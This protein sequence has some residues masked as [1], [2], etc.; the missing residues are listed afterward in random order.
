MAGS[1]R[2]E[3]SR[4]RFARY[5]D[6]IDTRNQPL[7]S[8]KINLFHQLLFFSFTF[9]LSLKSHLSRLAIN[10]SLVA[11]STTKNIIARYMVRMLKDVAAEW[12]ASTIDGR[13]PWNGCST[14]ARVK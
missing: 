4:I 5:P 10:R 13:A 2:T 6:P 7:C 1:A 9:L 12:E 3:P 11:L 8:I 14:I